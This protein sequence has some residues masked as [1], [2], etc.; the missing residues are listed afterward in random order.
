MP[1]AFGDIYANLCER[2]PDPRERGRQFEPLVAQVLR[3]D[4]QFR[5]RFRTVWRWNEWPG[6]DGGDYGIDIVAEGRDG[7]LTAIQCKCYDP[8]STLY[9]NDLA[10]FLANTQQRFSARM[11]VSTVSDW[12]KNLLQLINR[13]A[14]PVQRLDLFGLEATT[15][16]WDAYLE[17]EAAPLRPRARK[18]LRPHQRQVLTDVLSGFEEHDRGKLIM[19][20]G[21][22]KTFTALRIAESVTGPGG[23]VLFA[24]PSI[25]LV[26]QALREWAADSR[27]PIRAFAVCSDQKVGTRD[28]DGAQTYDLPIP[29][30]TD[31]GRLAQAAAPDAPDRLTVVFSTY[32]SMDV[33]RQAQDA[34]MPAFDIAVCDEAHRTTGYALKD[35][36]RS[37]FLMV[38][39]AEAIRAR[40][41]LYMTATPRLYSPAAKKKAE[42]ADAYVATMDDEETYGPELH[43]LNFADSV[44]RDL[45]SDYKVAILVMSEEQVA[46]EYQVELAD[47]EGLKVGDVGR[48]VGCLN[49][50][51]KLDPVQTQFAND[52]SPMHRAVA[53]SNTIKDSRHFVDLVEALQ[54]DEGRE[55]RGIQVEAQH[56][57]GKSG[58]L[59]RAERLAWLGAE[60]MVMEGQ[61]HVLSNARCLTEGID[62][63]ALDAVLFLQPRKSQIDVVQAVGRVMRKAEGK[64]YGYI[65]LPVVVPAGDDPSSALDR[66][67]AYA[68]VWE[69]LQ[70]LRSHDER[71]DAWV[72]KLDLNR[73]RDGGP[74]S[75]IGV[76]PRAGTEDDERDGAHVT[77]D[78]TQY[79]LSGLDERIERWRDA[80]YAKIVER[81][82]ERRYWEQWAESVS[83]IARRHHT[84]IRAL[85]DAPDSGVA[86]GFDEFVAALRNNLNDSITDDDAAGMLSQHLITKPVFDALFGNSEF[87]NWN[88]VSEVM[89]G[90]LSELEDKGLESET[91]ELEGFYASV[92]RRVEGIDNAE[93]RQRVAIELYDNFF[94]KA[95]PRDAERLGIVYTPVEI[96]DLIIRSV[97][98]LLREHF[99]ASLGDE[100]VHILDPFTGTGT[101]I[102][103]L[104][105]SGLIDA[106]DLPHKYQHELHANEIL[107]LAYYIAGVNIESAYREALAGRED[108]YEPF[109]GIVL[110]DTFQLSEEDDSMDEVFFPRNNARAERQ[111]DLDIRV[112]LGNPPWSRLQRAQSDLNPN[113]PYPTLD[114]AIETTYAGPSRS[115]SKAPLYDAYVRGI[116]WASNRVL[117]SGGGGIVAFVTN[118]SFIDAASFDG[119]RKA[120]AQEFHEVWVYNLRGNTRGSG[121][122]VR[123][124]G[125]KVF[126]SGS[127]ATVAV[128]LLVKRAEPVIA[129]AVIRYRDIGDYLTREQKLEIVDDSR[130][131]EME[132]NGITPNEAGDWINQRSE[133]FAALRPLV[134]ISS[135]PPG[136]NPLFG[137]STLGVL[138]A[139]DAWVFNS[140]SS[141][142]RRN[143]ERT[144]AFF[145]EQVAEFA[146]PQGPAVQRLRAA[147]AY[148]KRDDASFRWD[149]AA[150][151]RLSRGQMIETSSDGY[152]VAMYRPFFQQRLYMDRALNSEIYQIPR[153]FPAGVERV[154]GIAITAKRV[155]ES[156]GVLAVDTIPDYH[157]TGAGTDTQFLPR[158]VFARPV[159][160]P[161]QGELLPNAENKRLDNISAEALAE[162]RARLGADV[163]AD[164]VFAYIYGILHSP[165]YRSRY[166]TDLDRLLARIPDPADRTTFNAFADA[167]Q[168]L[169]DLHIGY[170]GAQPYPLDEQVAPGTPPEPGL[171]R[172]ERMRWGG[173]VRSPDRSRIVYNEWI[174]LAGI[175]NEAHEY[176]VGRRSALEWLID[177]YQVKT[178]KASGIVND[179]NDWGLELREP[180]YI[181]DLVKRIVTVSVETMRIVR[182]LPELREAS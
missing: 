14:P 19:A 73:D 105:H 128:L 121:E 93:G 156:F 102:V 88:P 147:R 97:A 50:L 138:G 76:G 28:G 150:E 125:G 17:D 144:A 52:P 85:I 182:G 178:D 91:E 99:G 79:V 51:A 174:T 95:F 159:R 149:R 114:A 179:V 130:F 162:Y 155:D 78:A 100:G 152:R 171:Y 132:W 56:V 5:N 111:R 43:R 46:R 45:L 48:V 92:R 2:Y 70:A 109:G 49:G 64:Q 59:V 69:V 30:S 172:V 166:A 143:I 133:R 57:D 37:S 44:E 3:T 71:F 15:I 65:I 58:V 81:C 175:P 151:R 75:V 12:S 7:D 61:C 33:I 167:G 160:P 9:A 165:E 127:R 82:G 4:S 1:T 42:A 181:L 113:Q 136:R 98:G 123:R 115:G 36:E 141:G 32:Q 84:R 34:G 135:Q 96:V 11:V 54:D 55:Q 117:G 158:Y 25:S 142:L 145:N 118:G 157:L 40:K 83:E 139:R 140:S 62:V 29:A 103:R 20:C 153:V 108:A 72:N 137:F 131:A 163:T 148:A 110:T 23:R 176:V 126:G 90:V 41:R 101:F 170:E 146:P 26:A 168:Q 74:V 119:F 161:S 8:S 129:P 154:P 116:R 68:H 66:N 24:A 63:P 77:E 86:E 6:R 106:D 112:I 94:R 22:G 18:E 169:L 122:T 180:R 89:Q 177:R 10:T 80:I 67:T 60:T 120:V 27:T 107:L 173:H 134:A 13:Q 87:T 35:E 124:E 38:H 53:F 104:L 39:D 164:H 47:S 31:P 16:D 21:T